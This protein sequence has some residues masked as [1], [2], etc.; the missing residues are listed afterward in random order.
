MTAESPTFVSEYHRIDARL[1]LLQSS[2]S[3]WRA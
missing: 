1:P 3:A 2:T